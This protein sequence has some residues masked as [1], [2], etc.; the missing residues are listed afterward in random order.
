MIKGIAKKVQAEFNIEVDV[1]V[2]PI[3]VA[4]MMTAEYLKRELQK[5]MEYIRSADLVVVPGSVTGDVSGVSEVIGLN[6]VKGP[7]YAHDIPLMIRGILSGLR[8]SSVSPADE[9]IRDDIKASEKRT[10]EDARSRALK[11]ALFNIGEIPISSHYPVVI[12]ELYLHDE[13]EVDKHISAVEWADLISVG[14]SWGF[15][16]DKASRI[17]KSMRE[18]LSGKPVGIDSAELSLVLHLADLV[19]FIN[20]VPISKIDWLLNVT[21]TIKS[22][23]IILVNDICASIDCTDKLIDS[24]N[25]LRSRGYD[26]VILDPIL[27]PPPFGLTRSIEFYSKLKR[28]SP[29]TPLVMGVGNVTELSDVDSIGINALLAFIGVEIGVEAY[30]TTEYSVKAR[31]STRELRRALDMAVLARDLKRPPKD[32]S[33]NLLVAKSKKRLEFHLPKT[34]NVI[35]AGNRLPLRLDPRGYFKV[36]VDH[37][38]GEIVVQHYTS[39]SIQPSVEIRGTDPYEILAEIVKRDLASLNEHYF[40]LGVELSKAQIALKLGKE[41]EQDRDLF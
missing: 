18:R 19:D 37:D 25:L 23:P 1:I 30:I 2:L 22:K 15:A 7:R 17:V 40:Y 27:H 33:I 38:H 20:G 8:F 31:G 4:A 39:S 3:P 11:E 9:I 5:Y 12:L 26:R 6:V 16:S 36:A 34:D 35:R 14:F 32:L 21:D 41:Y 10:L 28:D 29:T 13:G 24:V